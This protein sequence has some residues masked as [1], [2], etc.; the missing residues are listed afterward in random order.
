MAI[1]EPQESTALVT[2]W[3]ERA[4]IARYAAKTE[5]V[6][7][8]YRGKFEDCLI[9]MQ[10]GAEIGIPPL[11][12]LQCVAV[13]NGR[14]GVFGDGFLGVVMAA[15]TY[16]G[17]KEYYV[18][19]DGE[20]T[21]AL[22]QVDYTRDETR[23][24]AAFYRRGLDAPFVAEF[25]IAD[26]KRARL[27]NKDGPWREY[28]ARMLKWRAREYAARDA[29]APELRGIAIA[30][31]IEAD[32]EPFE[33]PPIL[34]PVR[35]SE[36]LTLHLEPQAEPAP[37]RVPGYAGEPPP[38][39][40]PPMPPESPQ[41]PVEPDPFGE[42]WTQQAEPARAPGANLPPLP[43]T[44]KLAPPIRDIKPD[45]HGA[46]DSVVVTDTAYIQ[47]GKTNE[48]PYYEIRARLTAE[49]KPPIAYVFVT[50]DK[51]LYELAA[52]AEGSEQTF[53]VTWRNAKRQDGSACKILDSIEAN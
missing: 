1:V 44:S 52:S 35:R 39:A 43:F 21:N 51:P 49:G 5:M 34:A 18:T 41:S 37:V 38:T 9:A 32:G 31:L 8:Q 12:A 46:A 16:R 27:W 48:E 25:S 7:K 24:V 47:R 22:S 6:P 28:P 14:P 19:A 4:E 30:E 11:S 15:R 17:H 26:A 20:E 13:I 23:A 53:A 50:R 42:E 29:F 45:P 2:T 10:Y 33:A 36:K 40:A 3:Q